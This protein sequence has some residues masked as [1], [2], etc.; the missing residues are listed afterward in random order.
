MTQLYLYRR[1]LAVENDGDL[2]FVVLVFL[3]AD[4]EYLFVATLLVALDVKTGVAV[5][6]HPE[7]FLVAVNHVASEV[8]V[9]QLDLC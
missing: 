1:R 5:A 6:V 9:Q 2:V 7:Q 4:D 3:F 8:C